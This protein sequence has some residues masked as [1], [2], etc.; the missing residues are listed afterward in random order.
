MLS[1]DDAERNNQ[2][3]KNGDR[4]FSHFESTAGE[5]YVITEHDRSVTTV[6]LCE[7]Y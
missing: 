3:I 7:D 2:A 5:V 4:V 6:M 1:H